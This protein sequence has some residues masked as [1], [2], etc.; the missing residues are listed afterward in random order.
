MNIFDFIALL[1]HELGN[2]AKS[3]YAGLQPLSFVPGE[4]Y[5]QFADSFI[6]TIKTHYSNSGNITDISDY[7]LSKTLP[8]ELLEK[9]F[10]N[11]EFRQNKDAV[12]YLVTRICKQLFNKNRYLHTG[13]KNHVF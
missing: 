4:K 3:R 5:T 7:Q 6:T 9:Y 10:G 13:G 2:D 1:L 11:T 12:F 8:D